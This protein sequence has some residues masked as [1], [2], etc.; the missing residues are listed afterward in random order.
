[1]LMRL[2]LPRVL[3]LL[4]LKQPR[5]EARLAGRQVLPLLASS[6]AQVL[7]QVYRQLLVWEQP[8]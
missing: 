1:M 8:S 5:Q 3:H 2:L 7:P 4:E 6:Q